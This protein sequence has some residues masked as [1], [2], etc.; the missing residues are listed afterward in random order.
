MKKQLM[1]LKEL[2]RVMDTD[3]YR[4]LGQWT[5]FP[6]VY[7]YCLTLVWCRKNRRPQFVL[8]LPASIFN[9]IADVAKL[10]LF[11]IDGF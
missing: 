4:H 5:L 6:T 3:L 11:I 7:M 8:L 2:I 1:T 9:H 10:T